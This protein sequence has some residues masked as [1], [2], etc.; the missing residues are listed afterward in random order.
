ME[1]HFW[2]FDGSV[3]R[4]RF[5]FGRTLSRN[6]SERFSQRRTHAEM[7]WE[8]N[9]YHPRTRIRCDCLSWVIRCSNDPNVRKEMRVRQ[10]VGC[11]RFGYDALLHSCISL[12]RQRKRHGI[13]AR[14]LRGKV[15]RIEYGTL[16]KPRPFGTDI[17]RCNESA[18]AEPVQPGCVW[19]SRLGRPCWPRPAVRATVPDS[20]PVSVPQP[21]IKK[22]NGSE[23]RTEEV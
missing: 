4:L 7:A 18:E 8:N 14:L 5:L 22:Q 2:H 9:V 6:A 3:L 12:Y 17:C 1:S 21:R 15:L 23:D 20:G 11:G 13:R 10:Q 19:A 16:Y